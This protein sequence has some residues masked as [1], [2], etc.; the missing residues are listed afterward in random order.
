M[1]DTYIDYGHK[2]VL[3][4]PEAYIDIKTGDSREISQEIKDQLTYHADNSTMLHLLCSALDAYFSSGK[5]ESFSDVMKE[6]SDIRRL[7]EKGYSPYNSPSNSS[8]KRNSQSKSL[9]LSEISD[10]LEAFGG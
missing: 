9:D 1:A 6:I 7:L 5:G 4:L 10:V 8:T 2:I 3:P